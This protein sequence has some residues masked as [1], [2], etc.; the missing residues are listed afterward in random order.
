MTLYFCNKYFRSKIRKISKLAKIRKISK[1]E[2]IMIQE[3]EPAELIRFKFKE[4]N[5]H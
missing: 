1:I 3:H 2:K 4:L 5:D